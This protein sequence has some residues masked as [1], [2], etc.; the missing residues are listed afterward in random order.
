MKIICNNGWIGLAFTLIF[1]LASFSATADDLGEILVTGTRTYGEGSS[2]STVN[3]RG[4][5]S[6]G[7]SIADARGAA[8]AAKQKEKQ[9]RCK[10]DATTYLAGCNQGQGAL[11]ILNSSYCRGAY[12]VG[13]ALGVA[14]GWAYFEGEGG[15][16]THIGR[17]SVCHLSMGR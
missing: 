13:G 7:P 17:F 2:W 11:H 1:S 16:S 9:K 3:S 6:G 15:G 14:G 5:S 4:A 10:S 8:L 12:W